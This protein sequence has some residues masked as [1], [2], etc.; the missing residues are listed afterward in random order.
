MP[1]QKV[2][3]GEQLTD[4]LS[5]YIAQAQTLSAVAATAPAH[6]ALLRSLAGIARD[7]ERLLRSVSTP[8]AGRLASEWG[9]V[10]FGADL[11]VRA[12]VTGSAS[13]VLMTVAFRMKN[14]EALDA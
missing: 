6:A 2:T 4:K 13:L 12:A 9:L 11:G 3:K 5:A 10:Q 8:Q 7:I 14:K 1:K